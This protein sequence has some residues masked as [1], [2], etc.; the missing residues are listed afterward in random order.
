MFKFFFIL[1]I[2][3]NVLIYKVNAQNIWTQKSDFPGLGK[4]AAVSFTIEDEAY[5]STGYDPISGQ[6]SQEVWQYNP[7]TNS[8][9]QKA[10]F[11][12]GD[13]QLAVGFSINGKGYIGLGDV[14]STDFWEYDPNN[15]TWTQKAD[16]PGGERIEAVGFSIGNK[17][18]IGTGFDLPTIFN[19]FWEY[20]PCIDTWTQKANLPVALH[21]AVGFP[22]GAKGYIGTGGNIDTGYLKDFWEYDPEFNTWTQKA[23][24]GGEGRHGAVGFSIGNKGYIGTGFSIAPVPLN[25]SDFWEY[26]P[27]TDSWEQ[28]TDFGGDARCFAIGFSVCNKGYI[29]IGGQFSINPP[30]PFTDIWEYTLETSGIDGKEPDNSQLNNYFSL[31]NYPNPFNPSTTISYSLQTAEKVELII[32]NLRGQKVITLVSEVL[33]AGEHSVTWNGRDSNGDQVGSG[34]YFYKLKTGRYEK[35]RKMIL[36]K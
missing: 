14:H 18:Y 10:D 13:R 4:F 7:V 23:D 15:D 11:A 26:D 8:W 16:F 12:G 22:I 25:Y 30:P 31:S 17:G 9:I 36:L 2:F 24:F 35:T 28:K 3:T 1:I 29:G 34:I 5:V 20:D 32:N 19:D 27:A 33:P 6:W 21:R